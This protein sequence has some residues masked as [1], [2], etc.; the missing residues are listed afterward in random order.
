[1]NIRG[2]RIALP[3]DG[4]LEEAACMK[5][6]IARAK[7]ALPTGYCGLAL[8]QSCPHP[9]ACLILSC[10][11]FLT[12]ASFRS[13]HEQQR[14]ETE[15]LLGTAREADGVRLVKRLERDHASL[16]RILEGLD[17]M[18]AGHGAA[19]IDIREPTSAGPGEQA[20]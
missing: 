2:E 14:V 13:V 8:V 5:E 1:V 16:T 11:S 19:E 17:A 3:I 20:A 10:P 15:R 18:L 7:Q 6:R 4:P 12:D 9:N